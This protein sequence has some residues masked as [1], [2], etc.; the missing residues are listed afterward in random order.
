MARVRVTYWRDIPVLVTARDDAEEATVPLSARFQ[1]L[2]DVV[3]V[4]AGLT[5]LEAYLAQWRTGPEEERDGPAEAVAC[6][7]AGA[8]EERFADIR[9]RHLR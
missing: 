5:E 6:A 1:E 8:L 2:V 4:Q 3:A 9:A 7:V